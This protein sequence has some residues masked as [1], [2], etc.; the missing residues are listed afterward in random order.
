MACRDQHIPLAQARACTSSEGRESRGIPHVPLCVPIRPARFVRID[1]AST[2]AIEDDLRATTRAR[3]TARDSP[4]TRRWP[5]AIEDRVTSPASPR[6]YTSQIAFRGNRSGFP[7]KSYAHPSVIRIRRMDGPVE[8]RA[9]SPPSSGSAASRRTARTRVSRPRGSRSAASHAR[10]SPAGVS[11]P[12]TA[13]TVV[14][15]R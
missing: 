3:A 12:R 7:R 8:G 9:A 13:A 2:P 6:D 14:F 11:C 1:A 15:R 10:S 5:W 4:C